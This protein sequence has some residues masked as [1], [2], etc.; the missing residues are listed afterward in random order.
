M[1]LA[2]WLLAS[3]AIG[4]APRSARLRVRQ[5]E[6]MLPEWRFFAPNPGVADYYLWAR[7]RD[8][9][10][11]SVSRR[12]VVGA[13]AE[14]RSG[15]VL[16][17]DGRR[18]NVRRNTIDALFILLRAGR[19]SDV[20]EASPAHRTLSAACARLISELAPDARTFQFG[21][22][23]TVAGSDERR[24]AFASRWQALGAR[25]R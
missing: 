17:V 4:C 8:D 2:A 11:E 24:L 16:N 13:P 5:I 22:D 18:R 20:V 25:P 19:P 15:L 6:W 9:A 12:V 14:T 23:L 1:V 10:D 21:V 7:W 3:A